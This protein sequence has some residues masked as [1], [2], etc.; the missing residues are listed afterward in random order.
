[1][2]NVFWERDGELFTPSLR[3]RCLPGT[4]R[5][6]VLENVDCKEVVTGIEELG[7]AD[8]IFLTSAGLG[9]ANVAEFNGR[10]LDTSDHAPSGLLPY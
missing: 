4:T 5:E 2:A 1:M 8:R 7:N 9:I 3:T 6:Y 10:R